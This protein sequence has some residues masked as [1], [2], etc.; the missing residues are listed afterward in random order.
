MVTSSS[1]NNF[2][3]VFLSSGSYFAYHSIRDSEYIN[4]RMRR[5][6][7][8]GFISLSACCTAAMVWLRATPWVARGRQQLST[9]AGLRNTL[10]L[11]TS[12]QMALLAITMFY[13]GLHQVSEQTH[14]LFHSILWY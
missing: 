10:R 7:G 11:L 13:T 9:A 8:Y 6:L 5:N 2:L 4:A 14:C 3:Y 12:R 1:Y